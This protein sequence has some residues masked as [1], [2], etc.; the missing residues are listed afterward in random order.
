MKRLTIVISLLTIDL[1]RNP[2]NSEAQNQEL[3]DYQ[4][5]LR[6][7][8]GDIRSIHRKTSNDEINP[9]VEE[10]AGRADVEVDLETI[11]E[12]EASDQAILEA[13]EQAQLPGEIYVMYIK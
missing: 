4:A 7:I 11:R 8:K 13:H 3:I 5:T 12:K 1:K 6:S 9:S 2:S 10:L